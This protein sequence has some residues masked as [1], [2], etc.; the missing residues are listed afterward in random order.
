MQEI[1]RDLVVEGIS[2]TVEAG[3]MVNAVRVGRSSGH[4]RRPRAVV[5]GPGGHG[6]SA[7][8]KAGAF[9]PAR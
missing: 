1:P 3:L 4:P 2:S 8:V 5:G 6:T 7:P 9:S